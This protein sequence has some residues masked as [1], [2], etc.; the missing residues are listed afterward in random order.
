MTDRILLSRL[1]WPDTWGTDAPI[2]VCADLDADCHDIKDKT[3]CWLYDCGKGICPY[4]L[5]VANMRGQA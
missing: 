4:L 2:T 3:A 5:N 1:D